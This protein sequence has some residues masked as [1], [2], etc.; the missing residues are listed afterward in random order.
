MKLKTLIAIVSSLLLS[1]CTPAPEENQAT[2][3]V[4]QAVVTAEAGNRLL[5]PPPGEWPG[6][7]RSYDESRHSPLNLIN[8][9]NVGKL[10]LAWYYPFPSSRGM[11]ATPLIV[12]GVLYTTGTWSRV[13]AFNLANGELLW[14]YDPQVAGLQ[15]L[16]LCCDVV[17]RGVAWWQGKIFVGTLDGRL[18]ALDATSGEQQWSVQTTD[19]SLPYSITGAPRVID[20]KVIIGNGGSDMG[21]RGYVTA[22][23]AD[24]GKQ[25]WRFYTVPGDPARPFESEALARAVESWKGGAWWQT[26]GGGTV[27]DSM[28]YD[29]E[30]NLLYIG[31]GNGAP[32]NRSIRSPGGGDN[33][34]LSSIVALNP[35]TGDYVWHYQ[36][37]PGDSWDY[38]A[39]QHMILADL[40]IEGRQRKVIMQAPKNG[41]F[42]VIDRQTGE[43]ISANNYVPVTWASGIDPG[44]GR[45]LVN[46]ASFYQG[47]AAVQ[48][49]A[50]YGGHNWHPMSYNP[51]TGL[52]YLPSQQTLFV[53]ANDP[54]Y[55]H[56]PGLWN[57]GV[58]MMLGADLPEQEPGLSQV[59]AQFKGSLLAWDPIK[60][61]PRWTIEHPFAWN[62]GTLSTAGGLVFQGNAEG[63][64]R[65]YHASSGQLLW[66]SIIGTG[67]IAAPVTFTYE[68]EQYVAVMA[69]QGG[70]FALAHGELL[71]QRLQ[72]NR[73]LLLVYKLG[74]EAVLPAAEDIPPPPRP[75]AQS[76]DIAGVLAGKKIYYSYCAVCH[77][78][79]VVAHGGLPDLR[80][81]DEDTHKMFD[82][83]VLGGLKHERGMAGFSEHLSPSDAEN[84][85]AYII[86]RAH[87]SFGNSRPVAAPE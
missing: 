30:L 76:A 59:K 32:W 75:P 43:L 13:Y 22:Y 6:H 27:W 78:A 41:F 1:A 38:T 51:R 80:W 86:K 82:A 7:G 70:I 56:R 68:G 12:D 34:Y 45:P 73:N 84:L 35:D 87:D 77:G 9:S 44:T 81:M 21:V 36:T 8:S 64:F 33:L 57:T 62:G 18:V 5:D 85:H 66:R 26:G 55:Q 48:M 69:G 16:H 3:N 61:E 72:R 46:E 83:I 47:Q 79:G 14:Q 4:A 54:A 25:L 50:P 19:T 52:V 11:E 17:N 40:S 39:T 37:T 63:E 67:I 10:G 2:V 28:A 71:D 20:G 29:P 58:D 53:Y 31:V 15:A 24:T 23:D 60:Q 42:Y 49:P 74:G 65:A